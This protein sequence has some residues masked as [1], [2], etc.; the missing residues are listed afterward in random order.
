MGKEGFPE[1]KKRT[2]NVRDILSCTEIC[3]W[4]VE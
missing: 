4:L 3:T 1:E 2:R